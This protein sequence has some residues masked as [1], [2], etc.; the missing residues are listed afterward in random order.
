MRGRK[1]RGEGDREL[2]RKSVD[3]HSGK[4]EG[5]GAAALLVQFKIFRVRTPIPGLL[6]D[7]RTGG[8]FYPSP[9]SSKQRIEQADNYLFTHL[10]LVKGRVS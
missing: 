5:E 8:P 1:K 9:T 2:R 4:G 7:K 10:W 3:R 6:A